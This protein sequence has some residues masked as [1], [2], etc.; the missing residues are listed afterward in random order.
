MWLWLV[1]MLMGVQDAPLPETP[2]N[3]DFEQAA[4]SGSPPGWGLGGQGAALKFRL[5]TAAGRR[6]Q[7][8]RIVPVGDA[9]PSDSA[10]LTQAIDARPWRG[11]RIRLAAALK[12][13]RPGSVVTL[14]VTVLRP[15]PAMPGSRMAPYSVA[16]G[17]GWAEHETGLMRVADDAETIWIGLG[18]YGD[19]DVT[20]DD[21]S[22]EA[23]SADTPTSA[24]ADAYL[25][26]AIDLIRANH[27]N[28]ARMDWPSLI[29][30]AHK[31]I[32]GAK[33]SADT[34]DTITTV[35]ARLGERHS[36][37]LTPEQV[38]ADSAPR[39]GAGGAVLEPPMPRFE[40]VDGRFGVVRLPGL[41]TFGPDGEVRGTRYATT[42]RDALGTLDQAPLCGWVVDLTE[43][44]GG[45]MWPMLGG[46][47]PLLGK[48]PFGSTV[49]SSTGTSFWQRK[50][51]VTTSLAHADAPLAIL[52]GPHTASSG[53]I[54]AVALIGR[55]NVR[56]F[57]QASAGYSTSNATY[58]LSDG[59]HLMVTSGYI[60]DRTGRQYAGP[61]TPDVATPPGEAQ[62]EATLW[63]ATQCKPRPAGA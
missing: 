26:R 12:V 17:T 15:S 40:L 20:I 57:G 2:A 18:V 32:A 7:G 31:D 5:E 50:D 55:A 62:A 14:F 63:L 23:V 56:T 59:A 1:A 53:E 58:I 10:M 46:L 6:G 51:G 61:L 8:G 47:D 19:A 4:P 34:Y 35:L 22:L 45:N 37:M 25:T 60:R 9:S 11:K 39:F 28:S 27:I 41:T 13:A 43:D 3:P 52:I 44:T 24:E 48:A 33:T 29:A 36:F 16:T 30:W 49:S 38:A 21:V 42:L 54:T